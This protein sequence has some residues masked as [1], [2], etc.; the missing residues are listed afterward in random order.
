MKRLG[1]VAGLVV[2]FGLCGTATAIPIAIFDF[3][4]EVTDVNDSLAFPCNSSSSLARCGF[5]ANGMI[6]GDRFVGSY[7]FDIQTP[8]GPFSIENGT[9]YLM[10]EPTDFLNVLVGSGHSFPAFGVTFRDNR[11]YITPDEYTMGSSNGSGAL[12]EFGFL[13]GWFDPAGLTTEQ[14]TDAPPSLTNVSVNRGYFNIQSPFN[15]QQEASLKFSLVSLTARSI[16]PVP[17]PGTLALM[18]IGVAG[19]GYST[20]RR[21][22]LSKH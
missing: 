20:R 8:V 3:V 10:D 18:A 12:P 22:T 13:L 19:V 14:L 2:C 17:E 15:S 21:N 7:G 5:G 11:P 6:V 9:V 1:L 16:Q 4:A